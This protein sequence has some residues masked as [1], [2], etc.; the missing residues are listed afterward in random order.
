MRRFTATQH[1]MAISLDR[2]IELAKLRNAQLLALLLHSQASMRN[3][4]RL[5]LDSRRVQAPAPIR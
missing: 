3:A 5:E 4:A 1:F 2:K